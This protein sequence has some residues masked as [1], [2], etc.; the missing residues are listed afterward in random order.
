MAEAIQN[1]FLIFLSTIKSIFGIMYKISNFYGE[2]GLF[3]F[4]F[5]VTIYIIDTYISKKAISIRNVAKLAVTKDISLYPMWKMVL[6]VFVGL[7]CF[8]NLPLRD[9]ITY[10]LLF[11][12]SIYVLRRF[13]NFMNF[14]SAEVL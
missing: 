6:V 5:L 14:E 1:I 12:Y 9:N 11:V 13:L 10:I 4:I 2:Y 7:D 8:I 3:F